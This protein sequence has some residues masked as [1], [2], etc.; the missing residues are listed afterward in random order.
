MIAGIT[1]HRKLEH[2]PDS[3]KKVLKD[4]FELFGVKKVVTGMALGFDTIAAQ[5]AVEM[6]IPFVAALPFVEQAKLWKESDIEIYMDLLDKASDIYIQPD[7]YDKNRIMAGYFGRNNWIV[8]Q[9]NILFAYMIN[10]KDGG[11]AHT[12]K[13][14]VKKGIPSINL[15]DFLST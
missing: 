4:Q 2:S 13:T 5:L 8:S 3:I 1:G 15:I 14:A 6:K 10:D 9:S 11:T 12:F 7:T